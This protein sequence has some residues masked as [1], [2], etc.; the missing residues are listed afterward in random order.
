M[1]ME[2]LPRGDGFEFAD[3]IVGG[4]IPKNYVPSVEKGIREAMQGGV[5]A[6]YPVVDVKVTLFDGSYHEV[7]SSDM[8]FKIAASMGFK[9]VFQEARPILLEPIVEIIVYAPPEFIGEGTGDLNKRRG[10]ITTIES[11]KVSAKVPLGELT[12]YATELRSFT[13]GRGTY[14]FKFYHYEEVPASTQEKLVA[15]YQKLKAEGELTHANQ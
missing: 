5:I 3:K 1:E 15:A 7:D 6:G 2:P 11:D 9:K 4:A 10:R 12:K 13:H 14:T 8:A